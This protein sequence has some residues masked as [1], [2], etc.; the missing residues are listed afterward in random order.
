MKQ[1]TVSYSLDHLPTS[2][3]TSNLKLLLRELLV[4]VFCFLCSLTRFLFASVAPEADIT[5]KF[6]ACVRWTHQPDFTSTPGSCCL[7]D[8]SSLDVSQQA[9]FCVVGCFLGQ[10]WTMWPFV[11]HQAHLL[12]W[13]DSGGDKVST[14][15]EIESLR[16]AWKEVRRPAVHQMHPK[17]RAEG[18]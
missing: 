18:F 2:N 3:L 11:S 4:F 15:M 12:L 17:C 7:E 10:V 9:S 5:E 1:S 14:G 16:L 6:K 13:S 8:W